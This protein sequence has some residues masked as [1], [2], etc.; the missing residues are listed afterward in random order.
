MCDGYRLVCPLAIEEKMAWP[1]WWVSLL[2]NRFTYKG[3]CVYAYM[4]MM[5][6]KSVMMM[7]CQ[8]TE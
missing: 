8:F 6:M 2:N 5:S 4:M 7:V 3:R 1:C